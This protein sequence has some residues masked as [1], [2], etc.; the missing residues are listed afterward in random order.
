MSMEAREADVDILSLC[1]HMYPPAKILGSSCPQFVVHVLVGTLVHAGTA[2][3]S[4]GA[5]KSEDNP[6]GWSSGAVHHLFETGLLIG[7]E[8][9]H[10]GQDRLL[11]LNSQ[12]STYLCLPSH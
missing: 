7:L 6:E 12:G 5:W 3:H 2:M 8:P 1:G 10:V 9:Y 11:A 4:A